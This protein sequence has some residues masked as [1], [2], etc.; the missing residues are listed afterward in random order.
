[1]S[2]FLI[3]IEGVDGSGK[4]TQAEALHAALN[5]E[6]Y[7]VVTIQPMYE[8]VDVLPIDLEQYVSPRRSATGSPDES[9]KQ[10]RASILMILASFVYS[11][12]SVLWIRIVYRKTVVV[13]DRYFYQMFFDVLGMNA[14]RLAAV[15]PPP[16]ITIVLDI[17]IN[18]SFDRLDQFDSQVQREYYEQVAEYYRS[19]ST[20]GSVEIVRAENSIDGIHERIR[21]VVEI[22]T[23][24]KVDS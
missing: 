12:L 4:S 19:L 1:M 17:D 6:G 23:T 10:E 5:E 11:L 15:F 20:P 16:D 13:C 2:A 22:P 21:K 7:N 8:L 3:A 24:Y 18:D 14:R 9:S